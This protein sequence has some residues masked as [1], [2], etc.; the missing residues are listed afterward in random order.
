MNSVLP[1]KIITKKQKLI[2]TTTLVAGTAV[3]VVATLKYRGAIAA[4]KDLGV[5]EWLETLD[6][7]GFDVLIATKDQIEKAFNS[8]G[9]IS[10][11]AV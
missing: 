5:T 4:A 2:L 10:P 9:E 3:A 11:V 1:G 6:S 7:H 8:I